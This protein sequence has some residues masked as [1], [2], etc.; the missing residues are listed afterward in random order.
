MCFCLD[1]KKAAAWLLSLW[2]LCSVQLRQVKR[3][4]DIM[5]AGWLHLVVTWGE[6]GVCVCVWK[7][8]R[9]S[10]LTDRMGLTTWFQTFWFCPDYVSLCFICI[11]CICLNVFSCLKCCISF[12]GRTKCKRKKNRRREDEMGDINLVNKGFYKTGLSAS[13]N[14]RKWKQ[15]IKR[16]HK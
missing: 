13:I 12:Y 3:C 5:K 4:C 9:S 2:T 8:E 7:G 6:E 15:R 1:R 14:I 10:T 11:S 16:K